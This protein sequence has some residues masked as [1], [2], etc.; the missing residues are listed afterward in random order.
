MLL[1]FEP[2]VV[3]AVGLS[4]RADLALTEIAESDS[5]EQ[6][7][8]TSSERPAVSIA[9]GFVA[10]VEPAS[11]SHLVASERC[12]SSCWLAVKFECYLEAVA[13]QLELSDERLE[14]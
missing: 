14:A 13:L 8:V 10:D 5:P 4:Q 7:F 3:V 12:K 2:L 1:D 6:P 9:A 11:A